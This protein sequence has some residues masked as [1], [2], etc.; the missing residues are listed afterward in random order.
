MTALY[1]PLFVATAVLLVAGVAKLARPAATAEALGRLGIPTPSVAARVL[2]SV[3]VALCATAVLTGA[4]VAW[5]GIAATYAIFAGFVLWTL[6]SAGA[7]PSCGCFGREDTPVAPLHAAFNTSAAAVAAFAVTDPVALADLD[8]AA[9]ETVLF[10][11]LVALGA[12]GSILALTALPR[13][14]ALANGSAA[15]AVA[16]LRIHGRAEGDA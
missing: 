3:E 12:W 14:L 7:V 5:A 15:P 9:H 11:A 2:G 10:S 4:P 13:L 6:R 1:G 8:L 16:T